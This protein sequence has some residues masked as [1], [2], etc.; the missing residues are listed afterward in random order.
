MRMKRLQNETGMV[1]VT[2]VMVILVMSILLTAILSQNLSQVSVGQSHV[3][4]IKAQELAIGAFWKAQAD[5][6]NVAG[7][8]T[9][10][11]EDLDGKRFTVVVD[12]RPPTNVNPHPQ[13]NVTVSF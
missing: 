10:A 11:N 3:D 4:Q 13:Y 8:P 5:M 1:L 2:V 7:D 6:T 12:S 9:V